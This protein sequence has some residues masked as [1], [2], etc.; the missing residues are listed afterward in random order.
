MKVTLRLPS[1]LC[2]P[3]LLT[4]CTLSYVANVGED[5]LKTLHLMDSHKL[6]RSQSFILHHSSRIY[7]KVSSVSELSAEDAA[8]T[9]SYALES[10]LFKRLTEIFPF[11]VEGKPAVSLE[12]AFT[13]AAAMQAEFLVYPYIAAYENRSSSSKETG[14]AS[15]SYNSTYGVDYSVFTLVIFDVFSQQMLDSITIQSTAHLFAGRENLQDRIEAA[16]RLAVNQIS[17]R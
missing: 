9:P 11:T 10:A 5:S 15:S 12:E 4:S 13:E 16:T 3:I 2:W 1:I 8:Q 7:L 6:A 14:A 17:N